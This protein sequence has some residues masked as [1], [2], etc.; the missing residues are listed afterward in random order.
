[1]P[2]NVE[3]LAVATWL[4]KISSFI[5]IPKKGNAK[6]CLSLHTIALISHSSKEI[7]K[8]LQ[9]RLQHVNHELPDV[10]AGFRK[11]RG[12]R[13]EIANICWLIKKAREFQKRYLL[14][15]FFFLSFLNT[16]AFDSVDDHR[17]WKILQEMGIPDHLTCL[18]RNLNAGQEA[19][20]RTAHGTTDW[21]Q[22]RE[23]VCQGCIL[24]PYLFNLFAEYIMWNAR[25]DEAQAGSNIAGGNINNLRYS[26]DTTLL[27]KSKEE[28]MIHLLKVKE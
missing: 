27:A 24:S 22:I 15:I 9:A 26:E 16:S 18:L 5:P 3:N 25:L 2:A 20:V 17:L 6:E 7:L 4:E 23:E 1:M 10:Q 21:F 11:G 14:F 28:L 19:T 13:D 8:T 12:M